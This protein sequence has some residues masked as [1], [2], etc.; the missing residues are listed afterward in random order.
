MGIANKRMTEQNGNYNA[1]NGNYKLNGS[2]K[3]QNGNYKQMDATKTV[4]EWELQTKWELQQSQNGNY[5]Q[6][7]TTRKTIHTVPY[8]FDIKTRT[9]KYNVETL[10]E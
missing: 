8:S 2:I 4:I 10:V 1:Q 6:T 9:I 5:K 7:D 3:T